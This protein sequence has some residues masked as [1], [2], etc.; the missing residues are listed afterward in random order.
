LPF[1]L[2][3]RLKW[4][5]IREGVQ[6]NIRNNTTSDCFTQYLVKNFIW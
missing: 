4:N 6:G 1:I 5:K 3:H 2:K